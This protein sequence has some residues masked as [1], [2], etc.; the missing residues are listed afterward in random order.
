[1]LKIPKWM[2]GVFFIY[3]YSQWCC[4]LWILPAL[5]QAI[6][7][8]GKPMRNRR[9]EEQQAVIKIHFK[10]AHSSATV[11]WCVHQIQ[12]I[13]KWRVMTQIATSSFIFHT[14]SLQLHNS[15]PVSSFQNS[16]APRKTPA[17]W[18]PSLRST[19]ASPIPHLHYFT[20]GR[21]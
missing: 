3:I 11:S 4:V 12:G 14:S 15:Y 8:V 18:S 5:G 19:P 6:K 1:M 20:L 13:G 10:A 21:K 9:L 7:S 16:L 17:Q 2:L